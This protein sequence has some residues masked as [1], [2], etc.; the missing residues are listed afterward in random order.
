[1]ISHPF[2][3]HIGRVKLILL[4]LCKP[5]LDGTFR[6]AQVYIENLACI[7]PCSLRVAS[8][9]LHTRTRP[10]HALFSYRHPHSSVYKYVSRIQLETGGVP[11][12][13]NL[14]PLAYPHYFFRRDVHP[15]IRLLYALPILEQSV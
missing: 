9:S 13:L 1:M 10:G 6:K 5:S 4:P 14:F 12:T 3:S 15:F 7:F 2:V 8:D 11:D